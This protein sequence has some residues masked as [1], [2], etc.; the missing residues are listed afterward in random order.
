MQKDGNISVFSA[1][2][3]EN[4]KFWILHLDNRALYQISTDSEAI[5]LPRFTLNLRWY[6]EFPLVKNALDVQVGANAIYHTAYHIPGYAPDLGMFYN[7]REEKMGGDPYVD[8]FINGQWQKVCVF[9]KYTN[10]FLHKG[11]TDFF[12]ACGYLRPAHGFKIGVFWPF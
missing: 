4:L 6:L 10:A 7:Q 12:S 9:V 3:E 2:V 5:P 1:S 8:A 11:T